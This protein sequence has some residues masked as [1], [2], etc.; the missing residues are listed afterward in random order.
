M[1][2]ENSVPGAAADTGQDPQRSRRHLWPTYSRT[3]SVQPSSSD[4]RWV[5][6]TFD[7]EQVR[8][9]KI[10]LMTDADVDGAHIRCC[11]PSSA[12]YMRPLLDDG[13]VYAAVPCPHRL[14]LVHPE[15]WYGVK[16]TYSD[17]E[18]SGNWPPRTGP[19]TGQRPCAAVQGLGEM[20][21]KQLRR[22]DRSTDEAGPA[23]DDRLRHGGGLEGTLMGSDVARWTSSCQAW[24]SGQID[25]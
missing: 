16:Y 7:L 20:D 21:A 22:A 23:G 1:S 13:R 15:T 10:A 19:D 5:S 4:W 11:S 18:M 25:V 17:D 8:Y 9:G 24:Q 12:R 14:D 3:P 2:G 6:K